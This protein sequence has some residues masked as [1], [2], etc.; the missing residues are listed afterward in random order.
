[1]QVPVKS[2]Q[3]VI[4]R[5]LGVEQARLQKQVRLCVGGKGVGTDM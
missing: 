1:M 2:L 4:S 5:E 3:A